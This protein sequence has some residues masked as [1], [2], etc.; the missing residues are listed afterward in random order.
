MCLKKMFILAVFLSATNL[1]SQEVFQMEI[2]AEIFR[3]VA[4][5]YND[6]ET[7]GIDLSD[8]KIHLLIHND[9]L[10][11]QFY[12]PEATS[13]LSYGSPPGYPTIVYEL[14]IESGEI[15]RFRGIR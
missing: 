14:D 10:Y 7:R 12:I 13:L 5:T 6:M 2:D 3:L 15:L 1:F 11:V 8:Y 9:T 4:I